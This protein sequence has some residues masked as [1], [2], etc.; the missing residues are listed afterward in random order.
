MRAVG[1]DIGDR[2]GDMGGTVDGG[3]IQNPCSVDSSPIRPPAPTF[4]VDF[5][6]P[7]TTGFRIVSGIQPTPPEDTSTLYSG[8]EGG[9]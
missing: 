9:L 5:L 6:V 1:S 8:G 3:N 4:N 2:D 7:V